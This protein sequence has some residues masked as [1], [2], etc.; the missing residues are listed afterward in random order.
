MYVLVYS[1]KF[2]EQIRKFPKELQ[3]RVTKTLE[4]IRILP[5]SHV[6]KLVGNP[7]Y[8]LRTG[9]YRIILDINNK[10]LRILVIEMGHRKKI[11]KN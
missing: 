8:S 10:E 1:L 9:D 7:Y 5:H 6:K 3:V 11:Y 4:R 2:I